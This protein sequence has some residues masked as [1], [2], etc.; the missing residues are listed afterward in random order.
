VRVSDDPV[1]WVAFSWGLVPARLAVAGQDGLVHLLDLAKLETMFR[2]PEALLIEAK[3]R[4][5]LEVCE[6]NNGP[7]LV[8]TSPSFK[9]RAC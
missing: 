9:G 4:A 6:V 2:K 8:P 7:A 3:A 1:W 5:G